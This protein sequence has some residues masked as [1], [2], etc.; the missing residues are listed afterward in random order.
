MSEATPTVVQIAS[1]SDVGRKRTTNQDHC[2][3]FTGSAGERLLVLCDGMGGHQGGEVASHLAVA[4]IGEVVAAGGAPQEELLRNAIATAHE[5]LRTRAAQEAGLLGMG[6]TTVALFFDGGDALWIAHVGD[7]RAYRIR[8]GRV[9]Q[10]TEDHSVVAEQLRR[11]M[12]SEAE[13]ARLP[14]NELLHAVGAGV[15]L[16]VDVGHHDLRPGDRF[17]LCSDGLWNLVSDAEIASIVMQAAPEAAVHQLVDLANQ[18]GAN[19]NVTV[20]IFAIGASGKATP[21][22]P[23]DE[24]ARELALWP[25]MPEP[26]LDT[27]SEAAHV[28]SVEEIWERAHAVSVARRN[29]LLRLAAAAA[30]LVVLLLIGAIVWLRSAPLQPDLGAATDNA[31]PEVSAPAGVGDPAP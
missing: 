4:T 30:V 7:S 17:L 24:T 15:E 12:I 3:D 1:L 8:E 29:R 13:A 9:E 18:R 10:L 27:G 22:R 25:A 16:H 2:G 19:D 23:H 26:S 28:L 6:T 21:V 14:R 5:R 20:Q 11:G 31:A